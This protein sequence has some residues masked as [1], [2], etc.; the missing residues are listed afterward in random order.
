MSCFLS[1]IVFVQ[2]E[3]HGWLSL[4]ALNLPALALA[5]ARLLRCL[6]KASLFAE[7]GIGSKS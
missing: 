3:G 4:L 2:L 6:L 7:S 5:R 1:Q